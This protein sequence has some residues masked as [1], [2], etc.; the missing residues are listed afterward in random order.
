MTV[1]AFITER[2]VV[3]ELLD[4]LGLPSTSPPVAPARS[5]FDWVLACQLEHEVRAMVATSLLD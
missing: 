5:T 3:R 1:L 4:H 2:R